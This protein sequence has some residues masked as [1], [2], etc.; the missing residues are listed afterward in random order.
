MVAKYPEGAWRGLPRRYNPTTN[1]ARQL[2]SDGVP[3]SGPSSRAKRSRRVPWPAVLLLL[4]ALPGMAAAQP[5]KRSLKLPPLTAEPTP[6]SVGFYIHN[7]GKINQTDETFDLVGLLTLAW[8]DER[9]AFTATEAT[10]PV[11]RYTPDQIWVPELSVVNAA[12]IDKRTPI[13]LSVRTDGSVKYVEYVSVTVSS[14][15]NL[16]HFPFDSQTAMI[17]WEP[18]SSEVQR[19]RLAEDPSGTGISPEDYVTLAEWSLRHVESELGEHKHHF[20]DLVYPRWTLKIVLKRNS[21]YYMLK[22]FLP[23]ILI[24]MASWGVFWIN[25]STGFNPQMSVSMASLLAAITFNI[26]ITNSIPRVPYSTF[27]D[28][29]IATSYLFFFLVILSLVYIHVVNDKDKVKGTQHIRYSRWIFPV[30]YVL[31]QGTNV[32]VFLLR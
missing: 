28:D 15:F 11:M 4:A 3:M 12:K 17:I 24:S 31:A 22:V 5:P 7:I 20:T 29:F 16:R 25:P 27:L 32:V 10:G 19:L 30:L 26:T 13:Q 9:L 23:L 2:L 1:Q 21:G 8:K 18:L 14:F 6:V